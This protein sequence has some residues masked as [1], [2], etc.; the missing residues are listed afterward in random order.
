[1]GNV[2]NLINLMQEAEME[3]FNL[4]NTMNDMNSE[5]SK[6]A[7]CIRKGGLYIRY[8]DGWGHHFVVV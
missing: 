2:D 3:N 8:M 1:M 7:C 6:K 4:V 5:V